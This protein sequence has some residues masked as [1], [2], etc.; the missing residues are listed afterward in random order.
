MG[1]YYGLGTFADSRPLVDAATE[2]ALQLKP[3]L[4]S[5]LTARAD[6]LRDADQWEAAEQLYLAALSLSPD[7]VE[8][9]AQYAQFLGRAGYIAEALPHARK[10]RELDPLAAIQ[11]A[12]YG[13]NLLLLGETEAAERALVRALELNPDFEVAHLMRFRQLLA[14]EHPARAEHHLVRRLEIMGASQALV[15]TARK[16]HQKTFAGEAD[17]A[18]ALIAT[19]LDI[20]SG[21]KIG[22]RWNFAVALGDLAIANGARD[23]ANDL[24]QRQSLMDWLDYQQSIRQLTVFKQRIRASGLDEYWR[25]RGWPDMCRP[26]GDD[27][28]ICN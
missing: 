24:F 5:A 11:N 25:K 10:A 2:Q 12:I 1:P 27:D 26:V 19:A 3:N 17:Q 13:W 22:E 6:T 28:F 4:P 15:E 9:N 8:T 20:A 14:G 23:L 18:I 21:E 7:D 16:A